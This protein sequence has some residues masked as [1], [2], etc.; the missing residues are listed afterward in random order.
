METLLTS[1][2]H[3]EPYV[4]SLTRRVAS[5]LQKS[6]KPRPTKCMCGA[7]LGNCNA[8]QLHAGDSLLVNHL[9]HKYG[10]CTGMIATRS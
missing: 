6:A 9:V 4:P 1:P 10:V 5:A 2:A 3:T 7:T 8:T